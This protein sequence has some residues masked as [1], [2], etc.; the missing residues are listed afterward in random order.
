MAYD[1][2]GN[3][4]ELHSLILSAL[5]IASGCPISLQNLPTLST[6]KSAI[7]TRQIVDNNNL[8]LSHAE[9]AHIMSV[10]A[11]AGRNKAAAAKMLGIGLSTLHRK[12]KEYSIL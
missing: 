5:T 2:P 3:V 9:K 6:K 11:L 1:Y 4:R 10:Y 7:V 12:I 8:L